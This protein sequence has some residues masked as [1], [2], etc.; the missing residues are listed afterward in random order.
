MWIKDTVKKERSKKNIKWKKKI[1]KLSK[2]K[3]HCYLSPKYTQTASCKTIQKLMA[4]NKKMKSKRHDTRVPAQEVYSAV[5]R[6]KK[7]RYLQQQQQ[8]QQHSICQWWINRFGAVISPEYKNYIGEWQLYQRKNEAKR[9]HTHKREKEGSGTGWE[10]CRNNEIERRLMCIEIRSIRS[11]L[12]WAYW[13]SDRDW[14]IFFCVCVCVLIKSVCCL[15]K[16]I[17]ERNNKK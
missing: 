2:K 1:L 17:C 3:Q 16:W 9:R 8:Q 4:T 14:H 15:A 12:T 7:S 5:R 10:W 6:E 13:K 11:I